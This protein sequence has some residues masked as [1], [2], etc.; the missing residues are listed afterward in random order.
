[1]QD[2]TVDGRGDDPRLEGMEDLAN[3]LLDIVH[4][5]RTGASRDPEEP[6]PDLLP[7][8]LEMASMLRQLVA[9]IDWYTVVDR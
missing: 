4:Y 7:M 9:V 6:D 2:W 8:P 1:L 3:T 5:A